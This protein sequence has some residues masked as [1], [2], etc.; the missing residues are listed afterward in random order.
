[1]PAWYAYTLLVP[2]PEGAKV[3]RIHIG[4]GFC[5]ARSDRVGNARASNSG[6]S[7]RYRLPRLS[8]YTGRYCQ[9]VV[10]N[11]SAVGSLSGTKLIPI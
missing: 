1:M 3:C 5:V 10:F 4:V 9:P 2:F 7:N 11:S 8:F 6:T